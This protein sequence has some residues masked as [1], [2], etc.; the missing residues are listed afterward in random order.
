MT[1]TVGQMEHLDAFGR[2]F[3]TSP[4]FEV[5][6]RSAPERWARPRGFNPLLAR[7]NNRGRS[8]V[9]G[10]E[11]IARHPHPWRTDSEPGVA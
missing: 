6:R 9:R 2:F 11:D 7:K 10:M 8:S 4:Q 1:L 3:Q 5:L